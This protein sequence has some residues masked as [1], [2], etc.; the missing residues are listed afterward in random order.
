MPHTR[1][2]KDEVDDMRGS[3]GSTVSPF[4]VPRITGADIELGN[5]ILGLEMPGGT[6]YEASRALLREVDGVLAA[7]P[8]Y[9]GDGPA[10][11]PA[12]AGA[13][14]VGGSYGGAAAAPV[15][16]Y[17]QDFG[18]KYLPS[19]G[20]C[21]YV[22]LNHLELCIPEV[23]TALDHVAAVHA[24]Y[25][26]AGEALRRANARLPVG[27]QIQ[28]L[29]NNSD[30]RSNSY[31]SH[32]N[33]LVRRRTFENLFSRKL[34]YLLYLAAYQVSSI[35]F[36]GQGKAGSENGRPWVP[37]Q[38][39]QRADFVMTLKG[40]Q[41]TQ[42]RPI[43]NLRDEALCGPHWQAR[44]NVAGRPLAA[45]QLA[46]VHCIFYD[47]NLCHVAMLLKVGVMQIILSMIE[48]EAVD[49]DL[50]LD[51]PVQSVHVWSEDPTLRAR[52]RLANDGRHVTALELQRMFFERA[53]TFADAGGLEGI[54]PDAREI[55]ALWG[56]TLDKLEQRSFDALLGRLDWILKLH[57]L[58]TAVAEHRDLGWQSPELSYLDQIY[59]SLDPAIGLYW[60]YQEAGT[61]D[62]VV[63]QAT[64][65]RFTTEPPE[66]TR[67]WTRAMLLRKAGP[68]RVERIDWDEVVLEVPTKA[69]SES[70]RVALDD[71]R[72]H[73]RRQSESLMARHEG[74]YE[75]AAALGGTAERR[76]STAAMPAWSRWN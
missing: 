32:L 46:R 76:A 49:V 8:P 63:D 39:S 5:F 6:G 7:A 25:R 21:I 9:G 18:R 41:T 29:A 33:F 3:S 47:S 44:G 58:E 75:T 20:G 62:Q 60:R 1:D 64:I 34:H 24:M 51:D 12:W 45:D 14:V 4:A 57:T 26:H 13:S 55:L 19:N 2:E 42:D 71:P 27:Q 38:L 70:I 53:E 43:V 59:A 16:F 73:T 40:V 37:Y 66:D 68:H 56:D 35:V 69:G 61:V 31:G 65:D 54:V 48:A 72:R 10:A 36:T 30:G 74:L 67:A 22:D 28:L 50:L 52:C 23:R 17:S 15:G 11:A